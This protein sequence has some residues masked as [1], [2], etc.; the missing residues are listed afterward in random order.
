MISM[1]IVQLWFSILETQRHH[2]GIFDLVDA[3]APSQINWIRISM[4][5]ARRFGASEVPWGMLMHTYLGFRNIQGRWNTGNTSK[6]Y[7]LFNFAE[8]LSE[9]RMVLFSGL[10][11]NIQIITDWGWNWVQSPLLLNIVLKRPLLPYL[12]NEEVEE[13]VSFFNEWGSP[14]QPWIFT[15]FEDKNGE[16]VSDGPNQERD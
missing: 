5:G 15:R 8:C 10:N 7:W 13:M 2:L 3:Q 6:S 4:D 9:T 16:G 1:Q 14:M 12:V 11:E